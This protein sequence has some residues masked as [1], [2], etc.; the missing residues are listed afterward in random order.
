MQYFN[1]EVLYEVLNF[2]DLFFICSRNE[3][4]RMK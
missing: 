4:V 3:N 1:I 2:A